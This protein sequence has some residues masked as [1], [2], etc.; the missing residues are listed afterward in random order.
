MWCHSVSGYNPT[1][2]AK[3]V[4]YGEFVEVVLMFGVETK[5]YQR[6]AVAASLAGNVSVE[7]FLYLIGGRITS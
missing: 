5:G 6:Q 7:R 1:A 2:F 3:L 4:S